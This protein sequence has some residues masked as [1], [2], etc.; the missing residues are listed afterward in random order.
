M[1]V[2]PLNSARAAT[3]AAFTLLEVLIVVAILVVLAGVSSVYVFRYLED[4]KVN[5]CKA[6]VRTIAKAA[7][8]YN[9]QNGQ[10]P[11]SLQQLVQ[12]PTGGKPY[13]EQEGL[14][15]PWGKQ[16]QYDPS[17]GRNQGLKPDVWTT[18][19]D[20]QTIGNWPGGQ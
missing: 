12:P 19:P 8:A 17:G 16:Y 9:I 3:R 6:D 11:D 10:L 5:R 2:R 1:V 15:D 18:T 20:G 4:A 7:D 14:M 13:I